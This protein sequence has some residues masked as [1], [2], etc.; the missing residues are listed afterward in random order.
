MK[1]TR[2]FVASFAVYLCASAVSLAQEPAFMVPRSNQVIIGVLTLPDGKTTRFAVRDGS[3]LTVEDKKAGYYFGFAGV[4]DGDPNFF[5][6][7]LN[8]IPDG[9]AVTQMTRPADIPVG[10]ARLYLLPKSMLPKEPKLHGIKLKVIGAEEW[11][12]ATAPIQDP[13]QFTPD[14]LKDLFGNPETGDSLCCITCQQRTTCATYVSTDCGKC[15]S[16]G[17]GGY[18]FEPY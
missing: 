9:V 6:H 10:T 8:R 11:E 14:E 12:F 4:V 16:G 7:R 3:W 18:D 13:G 17:G 2:L 1:W 15:G 5:V